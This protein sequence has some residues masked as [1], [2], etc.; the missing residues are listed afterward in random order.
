VRAS[1]RALLLGLRDRIFA[2]SR[3][4]RPPSAGLD[5]LSDVG[6][7]ADLLRDINRR[8]ELRASDAELIGALLAGL[9][10]EP[11]VWLLRLRALVGLDDDLDALIE[12]GASTEDPRA[13]VLL[14]LERLATLGAK[15]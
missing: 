1:D 2:W 6:A 3:A 11:H 14:T 15:F 5:L 7:T 10:K 8:Q 12:Q 9:D 13:H 4:G